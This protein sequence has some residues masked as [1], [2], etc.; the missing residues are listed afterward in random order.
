MNNYIWIV[1]FQLEES[2]VLLRLLIMAKILKEEIGIMIRI[3]K[4]KGKMKKKEKESKLPR[5]M[6][7]LGKSVYRKK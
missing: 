2:V 3:E 4:L 5:S 6:F 7:L 1:L